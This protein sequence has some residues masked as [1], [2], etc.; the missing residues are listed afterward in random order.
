MQKPHQHKSISLLKKQIK[1]KNKIRA[2]Y[3]VINDACLSVSA[4]SKIKRPCQQNKLVWLFKKTL[5]GSAARSRRQA[6]TNG[7]EEEAVK[8]TTNKSNKTTWL[9]TQIKRSKK[10]LMKWE[11][12]SKH[13]WA[14]NDQAIHNSNTVNRTVKETSNHRKRG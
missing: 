8:K 4:M 11:I 5:S 7:E 10:K 3:H 9:E 14:V 2:D 13:C 12:R 6:R 1:K